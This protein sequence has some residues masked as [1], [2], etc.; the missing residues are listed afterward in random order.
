MREDMAQDV[1]LIRDLRESNMAACREAGERAAER[2]LA[3]NTGQFCL[4]AD[5]ATYAI[6]ASFR[7]VGWDTPTR[8]WAWGARPRYR[9]EF[10]RE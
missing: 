4:V 5:A 8:E 9:L 7:Q 2:V 1:Q 6:L 3:W 10:S